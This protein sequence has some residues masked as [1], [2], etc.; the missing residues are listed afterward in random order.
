MR[1]PFFCIL[2][3]LFIPLFFWSALIFGVPAVVMRVLGSNGT[4]TATVREKDTGPRTCRY[5]LRIEE[6]SAFLKEELCVSSSLFNALS[7]GQ[8]IELKVRENF[9]GTRVFEIVPS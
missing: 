2:S 6:R 1:K 9:F 8:R 5:Q 3:A 4:L 7:E